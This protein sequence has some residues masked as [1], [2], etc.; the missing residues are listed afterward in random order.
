VG[1][2]LCVYTELQRE[3]RTSLA[4]HVEAWALRDR[5][6]N[7]VKVTEGLFTFVAIDDGGKPRPLPSPRPDAEADADER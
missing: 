5:R 6:G 1:D 4:I 2:V 7:R 3:G